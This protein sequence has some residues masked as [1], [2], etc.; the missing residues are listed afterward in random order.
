MLNT[1]GAVTLWFCL[2]TGPPAFDR[3]GQRV[4]EWPCPA[5]NWIARNAPEWLQDE[6]IASAG[7]IGIYGWGCRR[8]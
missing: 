8:V 4:R 1:F 6:M 7:R 3:L 5:A 2:L